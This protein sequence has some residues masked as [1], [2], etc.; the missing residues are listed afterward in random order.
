MAP[1]PA[2]ALHADHARLAARLDALAEIG[3]TG[4]G[5]CCRLALTDEDRAGRDLVVAWMR[6]LDLS[7]T[8]DAIGN[9]VGLWEVGEGAP[10]M[11]GSHI[12]TV[13]TGGRY[14]GNYGV[15]AG[16]EVVET[17]KQ[18]GI[19]PARPLA[20]AFFT[21]EEGSRFA[22]DMLGSLVYV[23]GMPL[24]AALDLRAIDGP[25]LGDELERIGYAGPLPC[26]SLTPAAYVELH[27]EQGPVLEAQGTTI[28]AVTGVQGISWQELTITGQSNH[29]G[30]TP[31][32][33][34]HDAGYVA[35]VL[36][37]EVR[38]MVLDMGGHQVGTVGRIHLHPDLVNVVPVSARV[39]VDLR[40]TDESALQEAE[41]RLAARA[42]ELAAAEGVTV[43]RAVLARFEPVEFAPRV[44]DLVEATAARLGHSVRRMPSGAGHDAQM[45]ARVCPTGMVFVP[46]HDGISH[47]PAEHT[48]PADLAAGVDVLLHV[49]LDLANGHLDAGLPEVGP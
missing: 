29:A 25:C 42:E 4:D 46:S 34:R 3:A 45:L 38:R 35:A 14:D 20:V 44:I 2:T 5:G 15:L 22:P 47:N 33:H 30:T 37:V 18:A 16:L 49:L 7:V 23:G 17:L 48:D 1:P 28:G 6:D 36:A 31:M 26:P 10:V 27:I 41:R 40:N 39:T 8:V 24:E 19:E 12:D 9:V 32:D 43:D 21:D 11:T 13:R